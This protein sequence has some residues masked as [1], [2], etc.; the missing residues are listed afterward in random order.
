ERESGN[1]KLEEAVAAFREALK[2]HTRERVPLNWAMTQTNLR[3]ALTRL[4]E[5]EGGRGS[6]KRQSW[7]LAR[8]SRKEPASA[9]RW[10]GPQTRT[11]WALRLP[12][13]GRARAGR[14]GSKRQS[15]RFAR[16]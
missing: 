13:S 11:I 2:E 15:S 6:W 3:L 5:R 10:I 9:C 12:I 1:A 7:P 8:R 4:G 14:R 16:P